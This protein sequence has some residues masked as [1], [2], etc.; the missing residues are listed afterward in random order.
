MRSA[1]KR[2]RVCAYA[3]VSTN[4]EKQEQSFNHQRQ[5]YED[6]IRK[7]PDYEFAGV[8]SDFGLSGTSE[9]RPGFRQMIEDARAGRFDMIITKS[10][11]RFARNT[12]ILLK[13]VRELKDLG[14]GVLFEENNIYTLS[15]DGEMMLTVLASFAQEESRSMSENNRWAIRRKFERGEVMVNTTRFLGYDKDKDGRLVINEA[16]AAIVRKIYDMYLAGK[17][18]HKIKNTLNSEGI[19]SL[20]G[21][22]WTN[23]T[24]LSILKN[25]KYK[26][27]CLLQKTCKRVF[28]GYSYK[29]TG[30]EQMYLIREDHEPIISPEEWE[31]VQEV[32]EYKR[33][34]Y[35]PGPDV[36]KY[37]N[38]YPNSGKLK[39][40]HCGATLIRRTVYGGK[41]EWLCRTYIEKGKSACPGVRV[42]DSAIGDRVFNEPTV[43]EEVIKD[44]EKHYRYTTKTEYDKGIRA[45]LPGEDQS[46]GILQGVN[47]SRRTAI[48]L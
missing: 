3:R 42:K 5:V 35:N 32:M 21:S 37:G 48:K 9:K 33:K 20:T 19:P 45:K 15:T 25:E 34:Q 44:G 24:I 16:Q 4:S 43:V 31:M 26:G 6:L 40:P 47:R 30:Q 28:G 14:I 17:G 27:D 7:N 10:I 29:N 22:K 8:Y 38:T 12:V 46:S 41:I 18:A 36:E 39:C 1:N 13:Y 23:G 2:L 11:S